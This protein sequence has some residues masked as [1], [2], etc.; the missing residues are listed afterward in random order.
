MSS[1]ALSHAETIREFPVTIKGLPLSASN[2]KELG[3]LASKSIPLNSKG[4]VNSSTFEISEAVIVATLDD[5][6]TVFKTFQINSTQQI[7]HPQWSVQSKEFYAALATT[8]VIYERDHMNRYFSPIE[9]DILLNPNWNDVQ[10]IQKWLKP[11]SANKDLFF[12]KTKQGIEVRI[13]KP[14]GFLWKSVSTKGDQVVVSHYTEGKPYRIDTWSKP[15]PSKTTITEIQQEINK[16]R[17]A[18]D[19]RGSSAVAVVWQNGKVHKAGYRSQLDPARFN[20]IS[21]IATVGLIISVAATIAYLI[22][23]RK[24]PT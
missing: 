9:Q 19:Y 10:N 8:G 22:K 7:L 1:F 3:Q 15:R 17:T 14:T 11:N 4:G 21:G 23:K 18:L 24:T 13:G 6:S 20:A 2:A 12:N 5:G 16:E